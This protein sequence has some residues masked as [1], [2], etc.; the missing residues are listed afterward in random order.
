M[1]F[2]ENYVESQIELMPGCMY[3]HCAEGRL[4]HCGVMWI[5][6]L[7]DSVIPFVTWRR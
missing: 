5:L 2:N 7:I 3:A 1:F 6:V 4:W